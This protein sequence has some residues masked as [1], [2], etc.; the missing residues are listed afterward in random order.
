LIYIYDLDFPWK[1]TEYAD[2]VDLNDEEEE[3]RREV[4]CQWLMCTWLS[5]VRR[6]SKV[7]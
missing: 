5:Q 6:T 1:N 2:D 4:F 3:K 7:S